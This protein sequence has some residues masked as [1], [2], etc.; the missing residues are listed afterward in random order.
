MPTLE[1][2]PTVKSAST[3]ERHL[4]AT[5]RG[6]D[7]NAACE[8]KLARHEHGTRACYVLDKCRCEPCT[9]AN[10]TAASK[11]RRAR[12]YGIEAYVDAEAAR[13]HIAVLQA[14]GL[15]WKRIASMARVPQS[16]VYAIL[17]GRPDRNQ[18]APS[19]RCRK[20]TAEAILAVPVPAVTDLGRSVLVTVVGARRRLQALVALG[21]SVKRISDEFGLDRQA[22]DAALRLPRVQ[23]KTAVAIANAYAALS[24]TPPPETTRE[25]R[26][27]ASR[28]RRRAR[29]AGW[30][31]PLAW[32]DEE[33]DLPHAKPEDG[34]DQATARDVGLD[35]WARLVSFGEDPA[36]AA[37]R[38]G[39]T[40][41]AI[42]A[43]ARR[44]GDTA[45][46]AIITPQLRSSRVS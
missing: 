13:E 36:R 20:G 17:Y 22:L 27:S 41:Y 31:P 24:M 43:R 39:V 40:L 25:Q 38:L 16:N 3:P 15:G 5:G 11:I 45:A 35:E 29:D 44:A 7:T 12:A 6:G 14:A 34:W 10:R 19:P 30:P 18:G 4:P 26:S 23:A 28:S 42:E 32:D 9:G 33:I 46:L 2:L 8:H 1:P 37:K 21:W